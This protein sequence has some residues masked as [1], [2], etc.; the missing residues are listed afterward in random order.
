MEDNLSA[1]VTS[2]EDPY[3]GFYVPKAGKKKKDATKY[4]D[5]ERLMPER[6]VNTDRTLNDDTV[7]YRFGFGRRYL[8]S[9]SFNG[10]GVY[11][12]LVSRMMQSVT[13]NPT[14]CTR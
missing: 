11:L 12:A 10:L 1:H 9:C 8:P 4:P 5:P 3:K 7:G 6:F 2:K 14:G 13:Q